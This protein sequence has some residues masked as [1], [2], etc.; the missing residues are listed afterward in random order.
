MKNHV[1]ISFNNVARLQYSHLS[2]KAEDPAIE[3]VIYRCFHGDGKSL[4]INQFC[5]NGLPKLI[6]NRIHHREITCHFYCFALAIVHSHHGRTIFIQIKTIRFGDDGLIQYLWNMRNPIHAKVRHDTVFLI[7]AYDI[8]S[9]CSYDYFS[10]QDSA[11]YNDP[12]E[13]NYQQN[14]NADELAPLHPLQ[15]ALENRYHAPGARLELEFLENDDNSG[16]FDS[17]MEWASNCFSEGRIRQFHELYDETVYRLSIHAMRMYALAFLLQ[18]FN[19]YSS[20]YFTGLNNG[21]VSG[22]L[23]FT[24]TFLIQTVMILV[25][26]LF[27]GTDGLWLAQAATELL[28]A[29][30]AIAYFIA[31]KREYCGPETKPVS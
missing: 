6:Y 18:G 30:I 5:V 27:L 12:M 1:G 7:I 14:M 2:A 16:L 23:A 17:E 31:R 25:L 10:A 29:V 9:H 15:I 20:A 21:L 3:N 13:V 22:I 19:E 8:I 11:F 4:F 28:A 26:P 24:R